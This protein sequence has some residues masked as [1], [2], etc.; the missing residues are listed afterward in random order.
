[1]VV[2]AR[3]LALA[4]FG[5]LVLL[6]GL[7]SLFLVVNDFG[8]PL[9]LTDAVARRPE[10]GRRA[11]AATLWR[12]LGLGLLSAALVTVTYMTAAE[13]RDWILPA[14]F[15]VSILATTVYTSAAAYFRA[16]GRVRGESLNEVV[17]R[18][19]VLCAGA[20]WLLHGGGLRAAV[21][22][23]AVADVAS[24]IT[25]GCSAWRGTSGATVH[26][27]CRSLTLRRVY[28]IA[29][30][31]TI[32]V[33]YYR[34]DLWMVAVFR[35]SADVARYA[36]ACRVVEALLLGAAAVAAFTVPATAALA[37]VERRARLSRLVALGLALT[38]PFAA[39]IAGAG[40][41]GMRLVFGDAYAGTG[42][43]LRILTLGAIPGAVVTVL[44]PLAF[45]QGRS[46][47][48]R[49]FGAVLVLDVT[50]NVALLPV[51]GVQ[52]AAWSTLIC[53]SVLAVLLWR[54][55][56]RWTTAETGVATNRA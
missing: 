6:L 25:L 48:A 49:A 38:L 8:L 1:M 28:P 41:T 52:A 30:A 54:S 39:V 18:L 9:A 15:A 2:A 50:L 22:V 27:D 5:D 51:I 13:D 4:D 17:S 19:F 23:Y 16:V 21:V 53:Q 32:G 3:R 36:S 37:P 45:L 20:W 24:A 34:V 11:L 43:L 10:I 44:G 40:G 7:G 31:A 12:R 42:G 55:M 47:A 33:L 46:R 14:T 26:S 35:G 56:G 29:L